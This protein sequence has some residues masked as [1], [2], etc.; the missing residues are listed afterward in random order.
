MY[1]YF[2]LLCLDFTPESCCEIK[3]KDNSPLV[4]TALIL[5]Y[6]FPP[7]ISECWLNINTPPSWKTLYESKVLLYYLYTNIYISNSLLS[8]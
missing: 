5:H 1:S 3:Y 7:L 8:L 6:L 4:D 2:L